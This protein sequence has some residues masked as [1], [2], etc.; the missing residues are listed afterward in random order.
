[1]RKLP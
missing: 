1:M